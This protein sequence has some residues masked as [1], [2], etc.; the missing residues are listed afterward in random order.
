MS[1]PDALMIFWHT[2]WLAIAGKQLGWICRLPPNCVALLKVK[3]IFIVQTLF[4]GSD[5]THGHSFSLSARL[6]FV[7]LSDTG[8]E[9]RVSEPPDTLNTLHLNCVKA[10]QD[11][12]SARVTVMSTPTPSI[13]RSQPVVSVISCCPNTAKTRKRTTDVHRNPVHITA[14]GLWNEVFFSFCT[15]SKLK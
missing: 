6:E 9:H 12:S 14:T 8:Y 10:L 7:Q 2:S 5:D 13:R 4:T 3:L 15:E 11:A 1:L